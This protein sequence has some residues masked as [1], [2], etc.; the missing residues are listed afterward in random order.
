LATICGAEGW[1]EIHAWAKAKEDWLKTILDLPAGVPSADTFSRLFDAMLPGPFQK[2]FVAW[3]GSLTKGTN[4]KL[5]AI[6]GKTARGSRTATRLALH[7]VRAWVKDNGLVLGQFAT[8]EKSNEITAIPELLDLLDLRG[9]MVTIDAMG[10]QKEIAQ[11]IIDKKADYMLVVKKNQL[12]LFE[13]L[14][15]HFAASTEQQRTSKTYQSSQEEGHG[16][17]ETRT[18]WTST[19]LSSLV[20]GLEWPDLQ[21]MIRVDSTRDD[22][23]TFSRETRYL[24]CSK[25]LDAKEAAA[26]VRGHWS[27]ENQCHWCLD[28]AMR[29]DNSRIRGKNSGENFAA[30]RNIALNLLRLEKTNKHGVRLKQKLCG[31]DQKYLLRVLGLVE[32]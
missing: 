32:E 9:A 29:E 6:D 25:K 10:T 14:E 30:L 5:V 24:I 8:E 21:T 17:K 26:V 31:W 27:I 15:A 23:K 22:G 7:V 3:M 18:V 12:G 13:E 20:R 28:V 2:A 4:G 19:A 16:R 11:K 1:D